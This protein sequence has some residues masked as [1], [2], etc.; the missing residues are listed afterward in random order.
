VASEY[1]LRELKHLLNQPTFIEATVQYLADL[2]WLAQWDD[3]FERRSELRKQVGVLGEKSRTSPTHSLR[4]V[5]SSLYSW[6]SRS[7]S[8]SRRRFSANSTG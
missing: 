3:T 2:G 6:P 7:V 4:V 8:R 1:I 5:P